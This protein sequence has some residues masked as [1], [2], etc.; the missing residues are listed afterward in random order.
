MFIFIIVFS[1]ANAFIGNI[2]GFVFTNTSAIYNMLALAIFACIALTLIRE[3]RRIA[4]VGVIF[5]IILYAS[6]Q[7]I[8]PH[9]VETAMIVVI[10]SNSSSDNFCQT[11]YVAYDSTESCNSPS[12][13]K[14]YTHG[15]VRYCRIKVE[16]ET[17]KPKKQS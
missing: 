8:A 4:W 11:T 14:S 13:G 5:S 1:L 15:I 9:A 16:E 7:V 12:L 6:V 2:F 3:A 10:H 17:E